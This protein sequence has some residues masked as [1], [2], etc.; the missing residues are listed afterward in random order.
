MNI[1]FLYF[2]GC[3]NHVKAY[4]NLV[5]VLKKKGIENRVNIFKIIVNSPELAIQNQFV[6]SPSIRINGRDIE[7]KQRHNREYTYSCR[8][9]E[10]KGMKSGFPSKNLI[11]EA[12]EKRS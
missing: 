6:G 12:L 11:L 9:Y 2:N 3:P 10:E 7:E 5:Q 4:E 1:E 8:I